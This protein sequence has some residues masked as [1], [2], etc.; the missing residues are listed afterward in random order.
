M[1]GG[2]GHDEGDEIVL[3]QEPLL[4]T[5]LMASAFAL[6]VLFGLS[7]AGNTKLDV[8]TGK[9]AYNKV[10]SAMPKLD[11]HNTST[12]NQVPMSNPKV[13]HTSPDGSNADHM[14]Q[15]PQTGQEPAHGGDGHGH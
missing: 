13:E 15:E 14:N 9:T 6:V 7:V 11:G 10:Q 3:H 8:V 2:H 1:A 12:S 5:M 4:G